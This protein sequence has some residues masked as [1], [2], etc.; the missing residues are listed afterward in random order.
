MSWIFRHGVS[1]MRKRCFH[2]KRS[3][4]E[5]SYIKYEKMHPTERE[6]A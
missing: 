5:F 3:E 6:Y 1:C 2:M 4:V